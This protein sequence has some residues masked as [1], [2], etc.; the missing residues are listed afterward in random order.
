MVLLEESEVL[1]VW[2]IKEP[3]Q[4]LNPMELRILILLRAEG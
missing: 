1:E 3:R 4:V 2:P